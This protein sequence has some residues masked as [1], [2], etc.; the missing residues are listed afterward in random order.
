M[1]TGRPP[2]ASLA[3]PSVEE[4]IEKGGDRVHY[5]LV[6]EFW[7][8]ER[9]AELDRRARD[10]HRR[11]EALLGRNRRPSEVLARRQ[12]LAFELEYLRRALPQLSSEELLDDVTVRAQ[13]DTAGVEGLD[14]T[15]SIA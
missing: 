11:R 2:G 15:R 13:H 10:E 7:V 1:F 4:A 12:R 6:T 8:R 9:N 14:S 3:R 5:Q